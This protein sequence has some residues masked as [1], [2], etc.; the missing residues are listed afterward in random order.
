MSVT[1]TGADELRR[2]LK[3]L[4]P[5]ML[6]AVDQ[7]VMLT[8]QEVRT[9]AIRSIQEQSPGRMVKRSRQGGGTYNH[10]AA[11]SGNAPN[12]DT[13]KLVAS[14]SAESIDKAEYVVGTNLPYGA[15][16][17]FGTKKTNGK[18]WPWL[19]PAMS[20]NANNLLVNIDKVVDVYIKRITQ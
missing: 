13:G 15:Y 17:E 10:V 1:V 4:G 6:N 8:A 5:D 12:T 2:K 18:S 16:L 7:G 11:N 19:H 20:A 9:F 14:I 3:K